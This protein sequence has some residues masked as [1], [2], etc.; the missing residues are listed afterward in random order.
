MLSARPAGRLRVLLGRFVRL[1]PR[2]PFHIF[3]PHRDTGMAVMLFLFVLVVLYHRTPKQS[4]CPAPA[5]DKDPVFKSLVTRGHNERV[6]FA[7]CVRIGFSPVEHERLG[8][9]FYYFCPNVLGP[10]PTP[11]ARSHADIVQEHRKLWFL[12]DTFFV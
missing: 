7:C 4:T 6:V 9:E 10:M 1:Q 8:L 5:V 11:A 12:N 2:T 3:F